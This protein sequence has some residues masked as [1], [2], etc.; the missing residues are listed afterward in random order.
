LVSHI[1]GER[2]LRVFG[3]SVLRR[4][5]GFKRNEV[6]MEWRKVGNEE[7][8]ICIPHPILFG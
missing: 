1:E 7:F 4:I 6:T 3:N 5:F 2:R 8:M